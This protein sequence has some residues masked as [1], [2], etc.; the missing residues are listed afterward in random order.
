MASHTFTPLG[1]TAIEPQREIGC[2][3]LRRYRPW[4]SHRSERDHRSA[5]HRRTSRCPSRY[6]RTRRARPR[7]L[8]PGARDIQLG[9]WPNT[10]HAPTLPTMFPPGASPGARRSVDPQRAASAGLSQSIAPAAVTQR[11]GSDGFQLP[12]DRAVAGLVE[13]NIVTSGKS[14]GRWLIRVGS[15]SMEGSASF[16]DLDTPNN[17]WSP[18][19][20]RGPRNA[21]PNPARS[22]TTG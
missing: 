11:P 16:K 22:R 20:Q 2:F 9:E 8:R 21:D 1:V 3:A 12:H 18:R 17:P 5:R 7:C 19:P 4:L 15:V 13:P 14:S 10:R 6:A